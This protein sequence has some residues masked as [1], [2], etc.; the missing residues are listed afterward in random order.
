MAQILVVQETGGL[1]GVIG[2]LFSHTHEV[3]TAAHGSAAIARIVEGAR[4]D[5]IVCD[6]PDARTL[7]GELLQFDGD[8]ARRVLF[9]ASP[10]AIADRSLRQLERPFTV[11]QLCEAIAT[12]LHS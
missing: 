3:V 11:S 10:A 6:V 12:I 7:Y 5:A 1:A 2:R 4:F 9:L 8:Q